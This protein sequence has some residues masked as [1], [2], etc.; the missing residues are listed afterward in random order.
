[1]FFGYL[2]FQNAYKVSKYKDFARQPT[3]KPTATDGNQLTS[4]MENTD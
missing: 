1:M 2:G 4:M 3:W